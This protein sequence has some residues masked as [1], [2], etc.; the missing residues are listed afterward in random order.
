VVLAVC[1]S[2]GLSGAAQA[3]IFISASGKDTDNCTRTAPCRTL[4]RGVNATSPGRELTILTSGEYGRATI[5]KGMTVLAEGVSANIRSFASG[6]T[7]IDIDAPG[8]KVA[9]KG[10]FITGGDGGD[11]G[12]RVTAAAAVHIENC[13][14]ER[15]TQ[16]G[17][18]MLSTDQTEL[19]VSGTTSRYNG[20]NGLYANGGG[21][22]LTVDNSRFEDNGFHGVSIFFDASITRTVSS[23]NGFGGFFLFSSARVNAT[24]VTAADNDLYGFQVSAGE[25]VLR[26]AVARGNGNVGLFVETGASALIA[27][28]V[29]THN[30]VGIFN[31]GTV[32][33]RLN[34]AVA[35]N[36]TNFD[37]AGS[38]T[39]LVPY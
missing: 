12:V 36:G 7:G 4:Q 2:L 3:Q 11:F 19:F 21:T 24:K 39:T 28:S 31:R 38:Y 15:F 35:L 33:T 37:G 9:L 23:H 17:I 1:A 10:L 27:N 13:T 34:S 18:R 29:F 26:S 16:D 22:R 14:V 20:A 32:R 25:I 30:N 6:S 5:N 8:Q